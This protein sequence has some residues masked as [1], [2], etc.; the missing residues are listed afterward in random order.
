MVFCWW[1]ANYQMI[2]IFDFVIVIVCN[3]VVEAISTKIPYTCAKIILVEQ[4][5]ENLRQF[6]N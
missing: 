5:R 2:S 4:R 6:H 3:Q 1:L